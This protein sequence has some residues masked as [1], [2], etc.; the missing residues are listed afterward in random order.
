MK[1]TGSGKDVIVTWMYSSPKEENIMHSQVGS[2]S[3]SQKVQNYYWR[4]VFLLFESSQRLNQNKRHLL[5]INEPPPS[6]IDGKN[7]DKL[8]EQY[9]IELIQFP[10]ITITP[11]D[12]YEAWNT[13]FIVLDVLDWLK[14][15]VDSDDNIFILDSDIIFNKKISD[16][17]RL[18]LDTKRA[19][20]Y[21][22][23]YSETEKINGLTRVDLLQ[24]SKEINSNFEGDEF[25]YNGGEFICL[26]GVE[27]ET[28]STTARDC[29]KES[30]TRNSLG[31]LKFNEEAHL[32]SYVY[33]KLGYEQYSAN[34][35]VKRIWTD[36]SVFTNIDGTEDNLIFW[37]LPSEKKNGFM[38][39]FNSLLLNNGVYEI[40]DI[41]FSIYYRIRLRAIEVPFMLLRRFSRKVWIT[42]FKR[43]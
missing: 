36:R 22:L 30:V 11:S 19:L 29:F 24:I 13:Q 16:K 43:N 40:P 41:D 31:K 39:V 26:K 7:I 27:I 10:Q 23:N 21:T 17:L 33:Y 2:K 42:F 5:F 38:H 4:C 18:E 20:L 3:S 37:H 1:G 28:V 25:L 9:N 6:E 14:L 15:N 32:L 12:Y 34:E 8:I 35:Y